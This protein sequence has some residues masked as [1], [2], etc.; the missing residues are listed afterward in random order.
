MTYPFR[1]IALDYD[2]TL[3]SR[4][5]PSEEVLAVLRETRVAGIKLLLVT[6]RV[7]SELRRVF[8]EVDEYFDAIVAENGAVAWSESGGLRLLVPPVSRELEAAL[9]ARNVPMR[10]GEVLF[11]MD[12]SYDGSALEEITRLGLDCQL[13]RNRGALMILPAG[14]SKGTGL[15]EALGE[16]GIS[17]HSTVGFGDAENDH[18]LLE[19][20]EIGV[21]VANAIPALKR[22]ADVVLSEPN[23]VGITHFCETRF[24][25]SSSD[26][27]RPAGVSPSALVRTGRKSP[28]LAPASTC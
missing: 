1:A 16:L 28:F 8:P 23:G 10:R 22:H 21:A 6:G 26:S 25:G 9:I 20:C 15:S 18:A 17:H 11:A 27:S 5:R 2:G 7:L 14:V 24:A 3:T 19:A 12:A 4:E 13:V